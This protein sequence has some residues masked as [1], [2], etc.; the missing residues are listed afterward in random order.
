MMKLTLIILSLS[1][2]VLSSTGCG[3]G[4][5]ILKTN[6]VE[7]VVT[8]DGVPIAGAL[9]SFSPQGEGMPATGRTDANGKYTLTAMQGG[10]E[11][12]GTTSGNYLVLVSKIE[13]VPVEPPRKPKG[14]GPAITSETVNQ[15]PEIYRDRKAALLKVNVVAGKNTFDFALSSKK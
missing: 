14:G 6:F 5:T 4:G 10:G 9:V 11:G 8:L 2:L 15:L 13:T 1:I 3:G 7:G 12:K